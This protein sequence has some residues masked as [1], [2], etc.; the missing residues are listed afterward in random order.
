MRRF[1][2]KM[3]FGDW[4]RYLML[5]FGLSFSVL[6]IT[7]QAAIFL[8]VLL[9]STGPLQNIGQADIWVASEH[10]Y[11]IDQIRPMK[12]RELL[13]VRSVPGVEWAEP[14]F[15][16][17]GV[18]QLPDG[19]FAI[20][21]L[22]GIDRMTMV[23]EP[24]EVI[25]GK[26]SDLRLPDAVVLDR[27]GREQLGHLKLGDTIILQNRRAVIVGFCRANRGLLSK[28][29]MYT[30]FTNASRYVPL[31]KERISYILVKIKPGQDIHAVAKEIEQIPGLWAFTADQMR[32]QS[33]KYI[34]TKTGIGVN[35]GITV[36]LGLVV[37][38]V[39]SMATF[40]Q[41]TNENL[42][43]YAVLKAMGATSR[44][45]VSM[46]VAQGALV[47]VI[48]Y[49]IGI[50]LAGIVSLQVHAQD[51]EFVAYFPWPLMVGSLLPVILCVTLGSVLSLRRVLKLEPATVFAR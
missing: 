36:L 5:V 7:Q 38:M 13:R 16:L 39:V 6:L 49:G 22:V 50:G 24:P 23:G 31:G 11:Y 4:I 46:I 34:L 47:T 48:S 18:V 1:A 17:F 40:S 28:P 41:F 14:F 27:A 33:I 19:N 21:N 51:G 12:D 44:T 42:P 15:Y 20:I 8:G 45:L 3:L 29:V 2:L 30:T 25:E 10:T 32:W 35:F 37:G 9:R 26:L 43:H